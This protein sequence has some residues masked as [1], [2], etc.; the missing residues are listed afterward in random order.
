M[1]FGAVVAGLGLLLSAS[2][3]A[4]SPACEKRVNNTHK[5]LQ[6][7][8]TLDGVNEHR[9]AF[10]AI[11]DANGGT[12]A[13]GTSGYDASVDYVAAQ[14]EA[15]GYDVTIQQYLTYVYRQLGPSTLEQIAP[16]SV[17]YTEDVDYNLMSNTDPGDVTAAVTA[18]DL[19]LGLGNSS[20]S[21]C[22]VADFAGFP[23]GNI[24]LMQ[25]GACTFLLKAENAAAAGAVGAIIFNQGNTVDREGLFNGTLTSD[26]SGGI[27]VLAT[28][29]AL[30][31]QFSMIPGLVVRIVA[32][33]TRGDVTTANV[34]AESIGGDPRN[35]VMAGAHL[36]SDEGS[37]GINSNGSG[38]AALLE[39]AE[40]MGKVQ[41]RNKLRFAWWGSRFEA[42]RGS[43]YYVAELTPEEIDD[44][45]LYLEFSTI[46]SPN[47]VR[48]VYDGD[49]SEGGTAGAPGSEAIEAL[50][51][52][53]YAGRGLASEPIPYRFSDDL[54]FYLAGI[55]TGGIYTGTFEIKTPDQAL[56]YGGTAGEQ[57]D[58]CYLLAC[59]TFDNVSFEALEQSTAAVAYSVLQYA[60]NTESVNGKEGKGNFK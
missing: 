45:A 55:P 26:Y 16:G 50:F 4:G 47:F 8:V 30:G 31:E 21:G 41:P 58:P 59:D 10:Q 11:A 53:F 32:D 14:L 52:D 5:K 42:T 29:Y 37:P 39:V 19:D 49:G 46:G 36:D 7:C 43:D 38:A 3:V 13:A 15:A 28:T 24:A 22:E 25:R 18:V 2:A 57:L 23:A 6:E 34:I 40:Q 51:S 35:V 54:A 1:I 60:M 9:S 48:F 17:V 56:V 27:P 20:T 44:I 12:R 33:V